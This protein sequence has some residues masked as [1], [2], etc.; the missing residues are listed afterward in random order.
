MIIIKILGQISSY[1]QPDDSM[2]QVNSVSQLR[3][4]SPTDWANDAIWVGTI[5]TIFEF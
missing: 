2:A 4:V 1:T 3:D 5:R